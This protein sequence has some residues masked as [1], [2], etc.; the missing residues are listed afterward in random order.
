MQS[1][2]RIRIVAARLNSCLLKPMLDNF[3]YYLNWVA[4]FFVCGVFFLKKKNLLKPRN[5]AYSSSLDISGS[6]F[7]VKKDKSNI[8]IKNRIS[9]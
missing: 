6:R 9:M 7:D 4:G 3:I 1:I 5:F 8:Y 2:F